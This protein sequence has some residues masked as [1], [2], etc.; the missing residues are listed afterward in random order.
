MT[1]KIQFETDYTPNESEGVAGVRTLAEAATI[2][3]AAFKKK[4]DGYAGSGY[5]TTFT[6]DS[7]IEDRDHN[8]VGCL[9][10]AGFHNKK[11]DE[12]AVEL[13]RVLPED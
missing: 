6:V 5:C 11:T 2:A 9:M 7:P 8:L 12:V 3:M 10:A 1:Y 4:A 13:A